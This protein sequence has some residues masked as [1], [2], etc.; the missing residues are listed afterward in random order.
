MVSCVTVTVVCAN[1]ARS[2]AAWS[3]ASFDPNCSYIS[4]SPVL[5]PAMYASAAQAAITHCGRQPC[6]QRIPHCGMAWYG[7]VGFD[8]GSA[9]DELQHDLRHA[10]RLRHDG[11]GAVA[12][13][14]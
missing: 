12:E 8:G 7:A 10:H 9:T 11:R 4:L 1:L 3:A 5:T 14:V 2:I 6:G 13:G